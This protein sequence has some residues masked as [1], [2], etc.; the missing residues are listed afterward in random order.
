VVYV[1][2]G[3]DTAA[4][5]RAVVDQ[6][7]CN[8]CHNELAFHGGTRQNVAYCVL[9]HNANATDEAQR[10]AEAMPP[11]TISFGMLA[12][13][14]HVGAERSQPSYVVYGFNGSVHD[15]SA[16]GFPGRLS[17]CETCHLEGSY[18]LPLDDAVQP[19][20]ITLDGELISTIPPIQGLCN[21]CHDGNAAG[22]HAELQTTASGIETC[23]VCHAT[24]READAAAAH[25]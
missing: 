17:K 16:V 3:E 8:S 12:H 23:E 9:C 6:A 22:G 1:G 24:G 2:P 25:E 4:P 20:S 13:G 7:L 15:Y 19:A 21:A 5:R 11:E 14:I 10:P 18:S